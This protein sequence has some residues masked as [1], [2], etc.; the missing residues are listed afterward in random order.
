M[1]VKR[2]LEGCN[3][4]QD[5]C[6]KKK[7]RD[8]KK[9]RWDD[10]KKGQKSQIAKE[11]YPKSKGKPAYKT[12]H[13]EREKRVR[14][15]K[16]QPPHLVRILSRRSVPSAFSSSSRS[17]PQPWTPDVHKPA[18]EVIIPPFQPVRRRSIAVLP[19]GVAK[20]IVT[21]FLV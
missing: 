7:A 17:S 6:Q 11:V 4:D 9:D 13:L 10:Q 19:P 5:A 3:T 15:S 20:T 21:H 16:V 1:Q 18:G 14:N 8:E 12:N 2:A